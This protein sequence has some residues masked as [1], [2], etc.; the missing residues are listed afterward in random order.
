[1]SQEVSKSPSRM[2]GAIEQDAEVE[3]T[4]QGSPLV[5]ILCIFVPIVLLILYGAFSR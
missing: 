4:R 1:M 2:R 5:P 3:V